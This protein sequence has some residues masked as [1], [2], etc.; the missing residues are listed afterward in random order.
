MHGDDYIGAVADYER[1]KK[2]A[3]KAEAE[4]DEAVALLADVA[5]GRPAYDRARAFLARLSSPESTEPR[6]DE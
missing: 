4:R 6:G 3:E 5:V 2:R 1:E